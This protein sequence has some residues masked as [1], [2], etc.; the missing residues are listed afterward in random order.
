MTYEQIHLFEMEI[1]EFHQRSSRGLLP[2]MTRGRAEFNHSEYMAAP[3]RK[4]W[5]P[6]SPLHSLLAFRIKT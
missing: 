3:F 2:L 6:W 5:S 1:K 4:P